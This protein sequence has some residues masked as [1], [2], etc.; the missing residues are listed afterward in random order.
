MGIRPSIARGPKSASP[1]SSF[2]CYLGPLVWRYHLEY[3]ACPFLSFNLVVPM[4]CNNASVKNQ[5]HLQ[6]EL[7]AIISLEIESIF[8]VKKQ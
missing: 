7:F 1:R 6:M 2:S 8:S 4:H 5:Y 3:M